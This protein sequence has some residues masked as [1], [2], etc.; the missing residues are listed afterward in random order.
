MLFFERIVKVITLILTYLLVNL[1]NCQEVLMKSQSYA[2]HPKVI[3]IHIS[4]RDA[5]AKCCGAKNSKRPKLRPND[6]SLIFR[7]ISKPKTKGAIS[8]KISF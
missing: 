4:V 7:K 6:K 3:L 1:S 5:Y 2:I 8:C